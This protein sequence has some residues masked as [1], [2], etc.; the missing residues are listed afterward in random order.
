MT[1]GTLLLGTHA[2]GAESASAEHSE[3]GRER[4]PGRSAAAEQPPQRQQQ[5]DALSALLRESSQGL[6]APVARGAGS[7]RE[8][9]QAEGQPAQPPRG[10][11]GERGRRQKPRP[12][13]L[14][15]QPPRGAAPRD[16]ASRVPRQT[17]R[18]QQSA[19]T[20][21]WALRQRRRRRR[22]RHEGGPG[23]EAQERS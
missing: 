7:E 8:G 23:A 1:A 12:H 21:H 22:E 6:S 18:G 13:V 16:A 11:V 19:A 2:E 14:A 20:T 17:S 4:S 10:A 9:R 3:R 5:L 15:Q